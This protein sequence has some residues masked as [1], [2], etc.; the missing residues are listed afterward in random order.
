L[1][2]TVLLAISGASLLFTITWSAAPAPARW[3]AALQ[4]LTLAAGVALVLWGRAVSVGWLVGAGAAL[5]LVGLGTLAGALAGS[6]RRSLL[7]RFDL[8][9]RFYLLALAAGIVGVTLG[10]LMGTGLADNWYARAQL[11]HSHLNL[12]GLV[13]FT[14]I[15]TLPTF[16]PTL[17][18][19]RAVS[20]REVVVGWWLACAA[21]ALM[22]AGLWGGETAV[23]AGTLLAGAG[24]VMVAV[25]VAARLGVAGLRGG[26]PYLQ[27]VAG[28]G[29]LTAWAV[30]DGARLVGGF[31]SQ[32][33]TG[34]T[35]AAVVA[36]VG[37]VLMGALTYLLPVVRVGGKGSRLRQLLTVALA[38]LAG[39]ALIL[40]LSGLGLAAAT[41][42]LVVV[43]LLLFPYRTIK[44]IPPTTR[45]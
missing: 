11:V 6:V 27:V 38:N 28:C 31:G 21:A 15:G 45:Q 7:R 34:W 2:G 29:W 1:A 37:Q 8:S 20:G 23:G 9:S 25:G 5:T 17:A 33:L 30:V 12:V 36:G 14:I 18:H 3:V 40:G 19:H 41:V 26:L 24:L 16:L 13:G 35:A 10:G 43:A 39:V 32:S 4:R 42:W 44:A 22:A